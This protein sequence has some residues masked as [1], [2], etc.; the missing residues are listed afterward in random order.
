M[1]FPVLVDA[2]LQSHEVEKGVRGARSRKYMRIIHLHDLEEYLLPYLDGNTLHVETALNVLVRVLL[3][4]SFLNID[5]SYCGK[6]TAPLLTVRIS[7]SLALETL[8][9]NTGLL[10]YPCPFSE[11]QPPARTSAECSYLQ[12]P[13]LRVVELGCG[14][15]PGAGG[16]GLGIARPS[17]GGRCTCPPSSLARIHSSFLAPSSS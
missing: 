12:F 4:R 15:G 7:Q 16:D 3:A 11:A 9:E 1:G 10:I 17:S 13:T 6:I 14:A 5:L 2:G 8:V